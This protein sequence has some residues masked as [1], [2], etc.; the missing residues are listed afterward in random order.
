M[1]NVAICDDDEVLCTHFENTL[2]EYIL[3]NK[4]TFDIFYSGESLIYAL[5]NGAHFDL[6]F[7]DIE[8]ISMD[9]IDVGRFI[10]NVINNENV[11]IVYI[12][13][14]QRYAMEL[15]ESRPMNFLVKPITCDAIISSIEKGLKLEGLNNSCFEL[16]KGYDITRIPYGEILYFESNKRKINIHTSKGIFDMYG[17]LNEIE[18]FVPENFIR[19]H[20]SFIINSTKVFRWKFDEVYLSDSIV[21]PISQKYRK[22]INAFLLNNDD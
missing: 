5:N 20:Q 22:K 18:K 6:I 17:K 9:G 3:E 13:V 8:L 19:I 16:K 10:R 15:F 1:Y 14:K 2:D 11:Q 12:S 4:I 7:I 21:I